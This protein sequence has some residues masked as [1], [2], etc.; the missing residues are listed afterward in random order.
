MRGAERH[1]PGIVGVVVVV[2]AVVV[3]IVKVIAGIGRPQPPVGST[4][5][6]YR[7]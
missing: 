6:I 7:I 2:I 1:T 4:T 5:K 3:D